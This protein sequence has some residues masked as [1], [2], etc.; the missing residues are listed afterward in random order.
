M[1]LEAK[2]SAGVETTEGDSN[3]TSCIEGQVISSAVVPSLKE[4][5]RTTSDVCLFQ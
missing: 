2:K 3:S 1:Y 5:R 4:L